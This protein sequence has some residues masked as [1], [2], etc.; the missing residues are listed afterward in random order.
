MWLRSEWVRKSVR[1]AMWPFGRWGT[2]TSLF[3]E[4]VRARAAFTWLC[5]GILTLWSDKISSQTILT[6]FPAR[7]STQMG[8]GEA[9]W[10]K[11]AIRGQVNWIPSWFGYLPFLITLYLQSKCSPKWSLSRRI[12]C[13]NITIFLGSLETA[14]KVGRM[15]LTHLSPTRWSWRERDCKSWPEC[16]K[17]GGKTLSLLRAGFL[18]PGQKSKGTTWVQ[19]WLV[20]SVYVRH[21]SGSGDIEVLVVPSL[22]SRGSWPRKTDRARETSSVGL[23]NWAEGG[24][25]ERF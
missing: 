24:T 2:F 10:D 5:V 9:P 13:W 11:P 17:D 25:E 23:N 8:R 19:A 20:C 22:S 6:G 18:V 1:L 16:S 7:N 3:I 15:D 4:N 14:D 21:T 12:Q